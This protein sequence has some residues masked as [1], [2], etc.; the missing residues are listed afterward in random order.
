MPPKPVI[1]C[2]AQNILNDLSMENYDKWGF[3]YQ[4]AL[5]ISSYHSAKMQGRDYELAFHYKDWGHRDWET[6]GRF[7]PR[8]SGFLEF[9]FTEDEKAAISLAFEKLIDHRTNLEIEAKKKVEAE[10]LSKLFPDCYQ[11]VGV[12]LVN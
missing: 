5:S 9:S 7:L 8:L 10:K 12:E 4:T 3:Q 11:S 1:G 2:V 6:K